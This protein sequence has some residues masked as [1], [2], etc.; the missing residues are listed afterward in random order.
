MKNL[1]SITTECNHTSFYT[2]CFALSTIEIV[3]TT[4]QFFKVY[5]LAERKNSTI[6]VSDC[7]LPIAS[8]SSM[9]IMAGAFSLA[10]ANAS[11][12]SFAPSPM[13]ICT[14]CGPANFK[15]VDLVWA[16]TARAI[17]VFPVP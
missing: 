16:A 11:R 7:A 9:K 10:R 15:N 13:N 2:N 6:N 8:N 3:C 1:S 12:T 4:S 5:I 14:S 17:M